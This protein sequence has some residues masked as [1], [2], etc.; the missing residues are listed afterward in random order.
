MSFGCARDEG[1]LQSFA[2]MV[3]AAWPIAKATYDQAP[4]ARFWRFGHRY[5]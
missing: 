1:Q 3:E 4:R 2:H 5:Q